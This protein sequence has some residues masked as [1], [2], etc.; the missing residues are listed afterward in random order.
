[1]LALGGLTEAERQL[2]AKLCKLEKKRDSQGVL[3]LV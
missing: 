3:R 2:E 1:M